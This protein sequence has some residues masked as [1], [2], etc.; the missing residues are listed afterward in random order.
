MNFPNTIKL[1]LHIFGKLL[2]SFGFVIGVYVIW[3][4]II[5]VYYAKIDQHEVAY[6][7]DHYECINDGGA[8]SI[9]LCLYGHITSFN[10]DD[11]F[12]ITNGPL[13]YYELKDISPDQAQRYEEYYDHHAPWYWIIDI[14]NEHEYGPMRNSDFEHLKD[15][16]GIDLNFD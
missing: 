8:N 13:Y 7:G 6:L 14:E 10:V 4:I 12:I 5:Y 2:Y 15:S 16:L 11:K 3:F 9:C 1:I